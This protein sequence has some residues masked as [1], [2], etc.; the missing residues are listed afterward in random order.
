MKFLVITQ[1][2]RVSGTSAG[3][4]RR[5]FLAKL[6]KVYSNSVIDVLYISHFDSSSDDLETLPVDSIIRKKV[7][8]NIPFDIKW[9]NRFTTRMFNFLYSENYI[10]QQY[11]KH[12]KQI[13]YKTYDHIFIWSSGINHETILA[14]YGLP[15]LKKAVVVFHDP[16]P[17]AWYKGKSSKIH[18]NEFLRLKKMIAVVQQ[19]KICC[20]TAY[21]MAKDL[22]YLYASDKYF[23]TLPHHF[24]ASAFDLNNK[25][26]I[27]KKEAR[28]QISYHG[29]LMFGRNIFNVLDAY[30]Q[31]IEQNPDIRNNT[32]F[33]LRVKGERINELKQKFGNNRNI[34]ILDTLDFSNSSN[35]QIFESDINVILENGPYYCNIL[36]GKVPFL[37]SIGK[38]VFVVSPERSE[39]R[40]IMENDNRYIADMK[41][42]EEI[43]SKLDNLIKYK[44]ENSEPVFPFG[45][46]F[47]DENFKAK[48]DEILFCKL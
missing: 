30:T 45:D 11:A 43:K 8:A 41:S 22:Q 35:E 9:I 12:I 5:S 10:L 27:R 28:L 13:D 2:L 6:K 16:Y 1:D 40:R 19:S 42:V 48:L 14:T 44:M 33:V 46:Y 37:A 17:Y 21:Y 18:K 26:K 39:L 29:A 32:E 20:A 36:P 38:P 25:D 7:S 4:G 31:L 34:K 47:S 3:I 23:Y 15:I 24:E